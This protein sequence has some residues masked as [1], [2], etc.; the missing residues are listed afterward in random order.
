MAEPPKLTITQCMVEGNG[1]VKTTG[2]SFKVMLNPD[3]YSREWRIQYSDKE[4]NG[5]TASEKKFSRIE[6]SKLTLKKIIIDGTGTVS[7]GGL[8][9]TDRIDELKAIVCKYNGDKHEP[10]WIQVKWGSLIFVGR[11]SSLSVDY[12]L[13]KRDGTPLRAEVAMTFGGARSKE[14]AKKK[15][16]QSS[17]DLT[18][19]VEVNAGDTLPLMC[20][21]IYGDSEY[22]RDVA[23]INNLSGLMT[24]MPGITLCF[25][26]L[27]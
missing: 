3:G 12:T 11:L 10:N 19:L 21:R 5:S 7:T 23:R 18:H 24:L 27:Q 26:P 25:P 8:S 9:V 17:P 20:H 15:A 14:E 1:N 6:P 16:N 2:T 22:Y 13:F 4:A